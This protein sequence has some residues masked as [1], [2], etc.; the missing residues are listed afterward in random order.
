MNEAKIYGKMI[1]PDRTNKNRFEG[2]IDENGKLVFPLMID[3]NVSLGELKT[4]LR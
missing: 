1:Y 3:N 4:E 2:K